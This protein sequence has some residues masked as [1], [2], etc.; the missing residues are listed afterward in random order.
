[1]IIEPTTISVSQRDDNYY[2]RCEKFIIS[3]DKQIQDPFSPPPAVRLSESQS[4][5]EYQIFSTR[6][7]VDCGDGQVTFF[8]QK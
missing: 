7:S 1:M 8:K 2:R 5:S 3:P 6:C 4:E